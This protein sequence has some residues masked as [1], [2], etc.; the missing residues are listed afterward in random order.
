[1]SHDEQS[2]TPL[3]FHEYADIFPLLEGQEFDELK[4]SIAA[5]GQREPIRLYNGKI[6]DGRN[7]YR[8]CNALGVKPIVVDVTISSV[9][10]I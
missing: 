8:A 2:I 4:Q 7:R 10:A 9:L 6:L 3:E 1:M 5:G